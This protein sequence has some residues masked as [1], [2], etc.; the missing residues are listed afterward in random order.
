[1]TKSTV[2]NYNAV[3]DRL[4][5]SPAEAAR[6]AGVGRTTI[7]KAIGSGALRSL[8]I[9]KR[10]LILTVSLSAW[11]ENAQQALDTATAQAPEADASEK[12]VRARAS[13]L[14]GCAV[15]GQAHRS[16]WSDGG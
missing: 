1:M 16:A 4:A 10:R 14:K 2:D 13:C 6:L 12:R 11:L 5:V 7:Y 8:K 9:G 3:A 15:R